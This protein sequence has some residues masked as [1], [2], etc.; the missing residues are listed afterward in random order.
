[1]ALKEAVTKL[2]SREPTGV[3]YRKSRGNKRDCES[4]ICKGPGEGREHGDYEG[5]TQK[6]EWT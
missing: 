4:S 1:M 6:G 5:L 2:M 3:D